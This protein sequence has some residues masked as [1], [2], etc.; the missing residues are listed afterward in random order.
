MRFLLLLVVPLVVEKSVSMLP[1]TYFLLHSF[2]FGPF[3]SFFYGLFSSRPTRATLGRMRNE[4]KVDKIHFYTTI[5]AGI[6]NIHAIRASSS[7][8]SSS[9]I[10]S[11]SSFDRVK[12]DN[13]DKNRSE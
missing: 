10:S 4:E 3:H 2:C 5:V 7:S 6:F 9:F 1:E 8:S 13:Y 11:S 12:D